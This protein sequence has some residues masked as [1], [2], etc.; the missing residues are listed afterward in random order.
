MYAIKKKHALFNKEKCSLP[1]NLTCKGSEVPTSMHRGLLKIDNQSLLRPLKNKGEYWIK[2][3]NGS[4][5]KSNL[6]G[7]LNNWN[8]KNNILVE[9][10]LFTLEMP[11][12][13]N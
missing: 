1:N 5:E 2:L 9:H 13:E 8:V 7:L 3:I 11:Y 4:G 10:T 6:D 12:L